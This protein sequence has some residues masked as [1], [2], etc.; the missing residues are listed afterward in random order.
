[1]HVNII[2]F[3]V[4]MCQ[5]CGRPHIFAN[6][7]WSRPKAHF[8]SFL[9]F[10][11]LCNYFLL[12]IAAFANQDWSRPKA[13]FISFLDFFTLCNYFLLLIAAL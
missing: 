11:T 6:Q 3:D 10:F 5:L 9:D 7:D 4:S 12:L 1:M 8:I 2:C 13:H